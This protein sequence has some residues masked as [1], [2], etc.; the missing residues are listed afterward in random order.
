[1]QALH[2][3]ARQERTIAWGA[4]HPFD[5]SHMRCRPIQAGENACKRACVTGHT[6]GN[7]RQA[8]IG[9]PRGIAVD[10]KSAALGRVAK[11]PARIRPRVGGID[12]RAFNSITCKGLLMTSAKDF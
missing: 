8:S 7:D 12:R 9:K 5:L 6:V 2:Q 3:I 11:P 4:D 1:M 10:D